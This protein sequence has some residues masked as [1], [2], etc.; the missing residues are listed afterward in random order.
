MGWARNPSKVTGNI[1]CVCV[2]VCVCVCLRVLS[3]WEARA[4][5]ILQGLLAPGRVKKAWKHPLTV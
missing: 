4:I 2:C 5:L 1:M 3:R